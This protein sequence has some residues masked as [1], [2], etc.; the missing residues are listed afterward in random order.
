LLER[1]VVPELE[2]LH[3]ACVA[4]Q[5]F[6]NAGS[7]AAQVFQDAGAKIVAVSDSQGGIYRA[8]GLDVSAVIDFKAQH[9]TV[10]G[11]PSTQTITNEQLIT[12][13]CDML[14]PAAMENQIHQ[15]NAARLACRLVCEAANGPTTPAADDLLRQRGIVVLPDILA[16]SGGVC[17]SYFEW[18][19]NIEN[20][21]WD[22]EEVNGK[23]HKKMQRAVDQVVD[24]WQRLGG[25]SQLDLRTAALALAIDRVAKVAL[26]RG[27][28]P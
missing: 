18:V 10:V 22:L 8:N 27:I 17:V 5:G 25:A 7:V 6:G 9:G 19:Q 4:V 21:Q 15:D 1:G 13:Q 23:L 20:E 11:M 14:I 3:G 16:N 24:H 2:S 26:A 28:W 12:S